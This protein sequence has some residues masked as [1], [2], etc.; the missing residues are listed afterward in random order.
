G[1][2]ETA[3]LDNL[4]YWFKFIP[5]GRYNLEAQLW[6]GDLFI[7]QESERF[8][9]ADDEDTYVDM[10]IWP[11]GGTTEISSKIS[12]GKL[13]TTIPTMENKFYVS[14]KAYD[15]MQQNITEPED[16]ENFKNNVVK[17][18]NLEKQI[19]LSSQKIERER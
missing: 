19:E 16:M 8:F 4:N 14:E 6:D 13:S 9:H 15:L 11:G 18:S 17:T 3:D 10:Y 1:Y 12:T 2:Y 5:E 7:S